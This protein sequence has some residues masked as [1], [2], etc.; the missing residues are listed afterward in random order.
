MNDLI[1]KDIIN[2]L[3]NA[4]IAVRKDEI[5]SLRNISNEVIHNASIFQDEDSISVAILVYSVSKVYNEY[6]V[7]K[8]LP[9]FEALIKSLKNDNPVSFKRRI[10]SILHKLD[11]R[12][13][14]TRI[15]I[16]EVL[17]QAQI[18]KASKIY[19]H[20]ISLGRVCE[21]L[22]ISEWEVMDYLGKTTIPDE[23]EYV[24]DVSE[25]LRFTRMLFSK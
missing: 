10:K 4:I 25:K 2:L 8:I 11:E 15:Y 3:S 13:R 9:E 22:G 19:E 23:V 17:Q 1:K 5:L 24:T 18:N 6:N 12:S 14:N 7:K 21:T 20:G 16:A